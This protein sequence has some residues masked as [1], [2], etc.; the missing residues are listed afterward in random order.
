MAWLHSRES[1]RICTEQKSHPPS[2]PS[3]VSS[4][5][6]YPQEDTA[7]HSFPEHQGGLGCGFPGKRPQAVPLRCPLPVLCRAVRMGH[8]VLGETAVWPRPGHWA[9]SK[10][11]EHSHPRLCF[12]PQCE[13]GSRPL[14]C[15]GAVVPGFAISQSLGGWPGCRQ[16]P[17]P[18]DHGV[19]RQ[20]CAEES[21]CP[22][23][24]K[25]AQ[26][27]S[28]RLPVDPESPWGVFPL[29]SS[30]LRQMGVNP[31]SGDSSGPLHM[32]CPLA[33]LSWPEVKAMSPGQIQVRRLPSV[34]P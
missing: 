25:G 2:Q 20:L 5:S 13:N 24:D 3:A 31:S 1:G 7:G 28:H 19:K 14:P 29:P 33:W 10:T 23:R 32:L 15:F 17:S 6:G 27:T 12:R 9:D 18:R 4:P 34:T 22:G 30:Q 8:S 11:R 26:Q 16:H 21:G